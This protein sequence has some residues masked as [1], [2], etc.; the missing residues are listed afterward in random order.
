MNFIY[1]YIPFYVLSHIFFY[2]ILSYIFAP[3]LICWICGVSGQLT[4]AIACKFLAFLFCSFIIL[5]IYYVCCKFVNDDHDDH[6]DNDDY[7]DHE[8]HDEIFFPLLRE[9]IKKKLG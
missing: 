4:K 5:F 6:D 9:V 3:D 1:F 8:D 7:D 2:P